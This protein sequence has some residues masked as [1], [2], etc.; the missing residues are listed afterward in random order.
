MPIEP[1]DITAV[2]SMTIAVVTGIYPPMIGGAGAVMHSL[3]MRAPEQVAIITCEYDNSGNRICSSLPQLSTPDRVCRINR[4]SRNL[5]WMP[6]GKMRAVCQAAYDRFVVHRQATRNLIRLLESL[7]PKVVCIGTLTSCYWV[8]HA[9]R[10][11][12]KD[13]KVLV[14]VHGEEVPKGAGFFNKLRLRALLDASALVAV[15]SFTKTSLVSAGVPADRITVITNGVDTARFQPGDRNQQIIDKYG[16]ANRRVLLTLAR[17]DERKGQDMVIRALSMVRDAVPDVVYLVVGEGD[18]GGTLRRL[19]ADLHLEDIV[20]F[21]GPVSDAE[22]VEFYRTCDAYVM[23]NRTTEDGDTE[24]F[25]LVFLEAGACGKPVIGG[26]AGGVPDAIKHE[27]T[28]LLV[29]GTSIEAIAAACIRLLRD[30]GLRD[31]FGA[32]GLAIARKND[33]QIKTKQFLAFCEALVS[34]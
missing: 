10:N 20:I 17:L 19:V 31:E 21:T 27:V 12:R 3:A 32:N 24:G 18:Y 11:W 5:N 8:V 33:W 9:V 26:A 13:L 22:A 15:S 2:T 16:L 29:D 25:G 7:R 23:P 4:L 28:G 14:Y 1:R 6:G 34:R 30:S